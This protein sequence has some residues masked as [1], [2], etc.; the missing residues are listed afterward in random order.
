MIWPKSQMTFEENNHQNAYLLRVVRDTIYS[1]LY[2]LG[3]KER[4]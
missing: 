4:K 1:T 2:K 3:T